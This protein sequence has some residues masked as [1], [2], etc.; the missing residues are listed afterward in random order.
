MSVTISATDAS[1]GLT[2][3]PNLSYLVTN[4]DPSRAGGYGLHFGSAPG[5]YTCTVATCGVASPIA[6]RSLAAEPLNNAT[7][8]GLTFSTTLPSAPDTVQSSPGDSR[9][10]LTWSAAPGATGYK[11]HYGISSLDENDPIDVGNTT[12][13]ELSGLTNGQKYFVAVSAYAW[14]QYYFAITAQNHTDTTTIQESVYSTETSTRIGPTQESGLSPVISD[15]PEPVITYPALPDSGGHC[16]IAT[17]A[18]GY[19]SAPEVQAL[20]AFRDRYLLSSAPGRMFVQWYYR[21][22]P[23]AAAFLNEHPGYKP[24]VRAALMPA[25]GAAMFMTGTSILFKTCVFL[26]L[27]AVIAFGFFRKRLSRTFLN[28]LFSFL[29]FMLML[30][31]SSAMAEDPTLSRPHWSLEIKGGR[32]TPALENWSQFYGKRSMPEYAATIAYKLLRQVE[33]GAG[34][35]SMRGKGQSYAVQ[36]GI[37]VGNVTYELFPVNAFILV[38]GIVSEDQWLVPYV[39]GGWTRMYY[40]EKIEDQNDVRGHA[41]G[42]HARGGLQLSLDV[43]EQSS[44]NRMY[45]DYGVYHTSLF[46]EVEY[47]R[48]MVRSVSTNLGGTAYLGGLLFEF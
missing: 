30:F 36:H 48:A 1:I 29:I 2:W 44:T 26:A 19:Y 34:A 5:D 33:V 10:V 7:L 14:Q 24:L 12:S 13:Y 3:S 46:V 28:T 40:R 18:Y 39:G 9:L 27:G 6:L 17:A 42:Y 15:F 11:V 47:S 35:G 32:F 20:R 4:T 31:P 23:V 16:F 43:I 38:R 8:N 41:D 22:G 21:R 37:A 25:V 45:I